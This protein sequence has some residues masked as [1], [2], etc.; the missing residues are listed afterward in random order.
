MIGEAGAKADF[1]E[2][3]ARHEHALARCAD[4][5]AM[6]VLADAFTDAAAKHPREVDGM[7]AGFAREFVEGKATAVFGL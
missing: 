4:A 2:R 1:S 7:D 6:H 5:E 3:S